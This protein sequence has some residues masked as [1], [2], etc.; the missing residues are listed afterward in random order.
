MGASFQIQNNFNQ[1]M[2]RVASDADFVHEF[3]D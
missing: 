1:V 2:R 3:L